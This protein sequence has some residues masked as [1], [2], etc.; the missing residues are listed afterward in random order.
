MRL[1]Q[2]CKSFMRMRLPCSCGE[3][4]YLVSLLEAAQLEAV[5]ILVPFGFMHFCVYRVTIAPFFSLCISKEIAYSKD[6]VELTSLGKSA[7]IGSM[8]EIEPCQKTN[9]F[10]FGST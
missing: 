8:I 6:A 7:K 5:R 10:L 2:P 3:L 1:L 4:C 9:K